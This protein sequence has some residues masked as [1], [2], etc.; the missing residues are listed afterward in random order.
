M[1]VYE[2]DIFTGLNS[3]IRLSIDELDIK[4]PTVHCCKF[5]GGTLDVA[6]SLDHEDNRA[7]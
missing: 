5:L 4:V 1:A 2:F 6:I 7:K 3:I